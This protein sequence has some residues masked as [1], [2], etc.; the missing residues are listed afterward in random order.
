VRHLVVL[1]DGRV[2]ASDGN[3]VELYRP[4][5]GQWKAVS[6]VASA[7]HSDGASFVLMANGKILV[8]GGFDS[9]ASVASTEVFDPSAE[10]W[11]TVGSLATSRQGHRSVLLPTGKVLVV[12]G[13]T[14]SVA[15]ACACGM[16]PAA[17]AE[18]FDP[19]TNAW[20]SAGTLA[21][22]RFGSSVTLMP[23]GKVLVV[24]G[25]ID[26]GIDFPPGSPPRPLI[27]SPLKSAEVYDPLTN[28]WQSWGP[29]LSARSAHAASLM[30]NG[31]LLVSGGQAAVPDDPTSPNP[32]NWHD[33]LVPT[34]EI[35][36]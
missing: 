15:H 16:H 22:P 31:K 2:L 24:G 6:A 34:S 13:G 18:L 14:G 21:T 11:T 4:E 9:G 3:R 8:S 26:G 12:A 35:G 23:T 19:A 5:I 17:Q 36:W 7:N 29:L 25:S 28:I 10:K 33:E 32:L 1:L 30:S 27:P 20:S